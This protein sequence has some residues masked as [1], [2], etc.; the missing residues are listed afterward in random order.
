MGGPPK[1]ALE[2]AAQKPPNWQPPP[3]PP[4]KYVPIADTYGNPDASGLTYEV[5]RGDQKHDIELPK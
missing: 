5:T 1:A 2:Q 3:K 4:G